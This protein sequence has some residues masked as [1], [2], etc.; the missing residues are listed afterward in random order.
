MTLEKIASNLTSIPLSMTWYI[1]AIE[2]FKGKQQLYYAQAPQKLKTLREHALIESSISSNRIEGVNVDQTRVKAV[3][4]GKSLLRDRDEEEVRG[5]Q[6][7]LRW[8]HEKYK[9]INL[10]E[11]NIRKLHKLC[12]GDIWDAGHFKEKQIDI[13]EKTTDGRE[14]IRFK[15]PGPRESKILLT[16]L[17]SLYREQI[18]EKRIPSLVLV[19][20]FDLDFLSIHPFRDGNGRVSRLLVLLL[21]YQAGYE[22]GRFISLERIV[23]ESKERYYATLYTSSQNWHKDKNDLWPYAGFLFATV[24]RAYLNLDER[25][26]SMS[27]PKGAK[28]E[29]IVSLISEQ[30]GEFSIADIQFHLPG[31]SLELIRKTVKKLKAAGKI[32]SKGR[33]RNARWE[34]AA[35]G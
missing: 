9:S 25:L 2:E 8:I 33:G 16:K 21:L 32:L 19:A 13:T 23:E 18:R 29:M 7:A 1:T 27:N 3:V 12:K 20:A 24:K 28:T 6:S 17:I 15:P 34:R 30:V 11:K 26:E 10:D 14:F 35:A 22:I 31:V 4:L 5:Y